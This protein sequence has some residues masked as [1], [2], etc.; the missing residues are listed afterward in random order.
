MSGKIY[1]QESP[2]SSGP[3]PEAGWGSWEDAERWRK[4]SFLHRTPAQR[5]SWLEEMMELSRV[6]KS[7]ARGSR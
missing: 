6:A 4:Q 5:L 7:S 3:E 1:K 2:T